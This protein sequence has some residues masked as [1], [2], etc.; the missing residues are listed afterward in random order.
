[1]ENS[2]IHYFNGSRPV[3]SDHLITELVL[4]SIV[5]LVLALFSA[6]YFTVRKSRRNKVAIWNHLVKRLLIHLFV[7][8]L[9]GG[10]FCLALLYHHQLSFIAP[11]MLIFYGL[12]LINAGK[13]TYTDIINLGYCELALGVAAMF[14]TG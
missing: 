4:T 6:I 7:P 9:A 1:F 14:F 12:S 10:L 2:G 3:Y 5:T 11:S 13:F 8:L